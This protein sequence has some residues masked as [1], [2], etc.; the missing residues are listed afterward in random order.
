[1][2]GHLPALGA[3]HDLARAHLRLDAPAD[4]RHRHR[5]AVLPDRDQRLGIDAW[6]RRLG[7]LEFLDRQLPQR[8]AVEPQRLADRLGAAADPPLQ[9]G[10]A[11]VLQQRVQLAQR[12]DRRHGDEVRSAEAADLALDSTLL[13][14]SLA[15]TAGEGRLV[16]VV[17]AQGDEAVLLQ[18]AAPTQ[19]LGDGRAQVVVA[20]Q[21]EDAAEEAEGL[22]VR[23]EEGLLRLALERHREARTRVAGA[24]QEEPDL[25]PLA[26]DLDDRLT[27]ID[28]GL[29]AGLAHLGHVD[30]LHR[31]TELAPPTT[32]IVAHGRLGDLGAVL[33]AQA[34][35]HPPRRVPLLARRLTVGD[36][37]P[38]DQL[39]VGAKRRRRPPLR[40]LPWRRQR[41]AERLP[42][43][44]P[45]DA[46]PACQLADRERLPVAVP[47][48][49]LE[50]LH[51]RSHPLCHLP[52]ELERARTSARDRT[53]AGPDQAVVVGP[54]EA[55]ELSELLEEIP[56]C[57]PA[58]RSWRGS[59][60]S[61]GAAQ[62]PSVRTSR[63][64]VLR[65]T[66]PRLAPA[67][68]EAS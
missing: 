19:D 48:D 13:A 9:V 38:V 29:D 27:P 7:R 23:L 32:H 60:Q 28:L 59:P 26:G 10:E 31:L 63:K 16:Q 24:H 67:A 17:R 49:L 15:A 53:R 4:E 65:L 36:E 30:L 21:V 34:L 5:V 51:P 55:V 25:E 41:R 1:M 42:H 33:I 64:R 45:V 39:S 22:H 8:T 12:D 11:G 6:R 37:P 18:P 47:T 14:R 3:D 52:F 56:R 62:T 66:L 54:S 35:P 50:Q 68:K 46:V 20:D 57:S 2:A 43:G 44:A 40:P 58:L 61:V